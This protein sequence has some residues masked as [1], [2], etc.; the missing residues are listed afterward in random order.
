MSVAGRMSLLSARDGP[1]SASK[2]ANASY[3]DGGATEGGYQYNPDFGDY[4]N[5]DDSFTANYTQ[6]PQD[7]ELMN[8][9]DEEGAEE[10]KLGDSAN[11]PSSRAAPQREIR[12]ALS[13]ARNDV[14][15]LI[16]NTFAAGA[17]L[18]SRSG[19][20]G[21]H[22]GSG[23]GSRHTRT[24]Q[25]MDILDDEFRR[26]AKAGNKGNKGGGGDV[27]VVSFDHLSA[28]VSKRVAAACF[29]EVLQLK[30]WGRIRADQE[31]PFEDIL[32]RPTSSPSSASSG[33]VMVGGM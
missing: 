22:S 11:R 31:A 16:C 18:D 2:S 33:R 17:E 12:R 19:G 5:F 20:S 4:N 24:E 14:S 6:P 32:L 7:Q 1:M 27:A 3:M 29:L 26:T 8:L 25:F 15:D 30:T 13:I 21:N 9:G 28:G 10:V 23:S